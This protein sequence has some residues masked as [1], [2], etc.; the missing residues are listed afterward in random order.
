MKTSLKNTFL[1]NDLVNVSGM[2]PKS[3]IQTLG[4]IS[5]LTKHLIHLR[6]AEFRTGRRFSSAVKSYEQQIYARSD[7]QT[8]RQCSQSAQRNLSCVYSVLDQQQKMHN[9]VLVLLSK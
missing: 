8:S 4:G 5:G 9:K 7:H 1:T 2:W 6:N 3:F